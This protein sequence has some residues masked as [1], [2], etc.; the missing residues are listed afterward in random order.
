MTTFADGTSTSWTALHIAAY[1]G[2]SLECATLISKGA[3]REAKTDEGE[4]PECGATPGEMAN[5][6]SSTTGNAVID[7]LHWAAANGKTKLALAL[8]KT[9]FDLEAED[10]SGFTPIQWASM[11]KHAE[12]KAEL[13]YALKDKGSGC[14]MRWYH[15]LMK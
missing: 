1:E 6:Q 12:T 8:V 2:N 4:G 10:C 14:C 13:E 11:E 7:P 5:F 15:L 3:D 9:G